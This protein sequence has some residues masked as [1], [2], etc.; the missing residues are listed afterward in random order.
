VNTRF[1]KMEDIYLFSEGLCRM[2]DKRQVNARLS[3]VMPD[4]WPP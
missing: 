1:T 2:E 3:G 4:L